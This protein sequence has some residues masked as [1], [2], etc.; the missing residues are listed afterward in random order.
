MSPVEPAPTPE[1]AVT[2]PLKQDHRRSAVLLAGGALLLLTLALLPPTTAWPGLTVGLLTGTGYAATLAAVFLFIFPLRLRRRMPGGAVSLTLHRQ[3]GWA[4][5]ALATLH[6]LGYLLL[7]PS[8][9]DYLTPAAPFYMLAG[10]L[11]LLLL[12]ALCLSSGHQPRLRL[13]RS[14]VGFR[15]PHLIASALVLLLT[16]LHVCGAG[17]WLDAPWKIILWALLLALAVIGL[18]R[19]G[20]HPERP[21]T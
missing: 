20:H 7:E 8:S 4:V 15:G 2:R 16:S 6:G 11:A 19:Q 3:L 10:L 9:L 12:L 13:S 21:G 17:L 18:L 14:R 5:L 1:A